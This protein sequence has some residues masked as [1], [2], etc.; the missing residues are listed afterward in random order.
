MIS[1][2]YVHKEDLPF[3]DGKSVRYRLV[4]DA[5][6]TLPYSEEDYARVLTKQGEDWEMC[7]STD[8]T[9]TEEFVKEGTL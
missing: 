6:F 1:V 7:I 4:N 8:T 3:K 5:E 9:S 2:I